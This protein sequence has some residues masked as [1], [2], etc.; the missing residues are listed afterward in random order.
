MNF[1]SCHKSSCEG[2]AEDKNVQG[3]VLL[4]PFLFTIEVKLLECAAAISAL[5]FYLTRG[6]N[7]ILNA[8]SEYDL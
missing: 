4:N 2:I 5:H 8:R 7:L 6:V 1:R 3:D